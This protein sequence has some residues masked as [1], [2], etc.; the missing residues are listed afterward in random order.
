MYYSSVATRKTIDCIYIHC[1][2]RVLLFDYMQTYIH[3]C[4]FVYFGFIFHYINIE[5][6]FVCQKRSFQVYFLKCSVR[7]INILCKHVFL[8]SF[9]QFT[10]LCRIIGFSPLVSKLLFAIVYVTKGK[11]K[12]SVDKATNIHCFGVMHSILTQ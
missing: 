5:I 8:K 1:M 10:C 7:I 9:L 4:L 12:T 2:Q 3:M 11:H 6:C